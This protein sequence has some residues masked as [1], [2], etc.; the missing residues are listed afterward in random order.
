MS[1][2]VGPGRW[3]SF[4]IVVILAFVTGLLTK[5]LKGINIISCYYVCIFIVR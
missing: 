4:S 2:I 1:R 5:G 3:M